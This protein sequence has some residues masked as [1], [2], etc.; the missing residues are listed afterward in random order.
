MQMFD[1]PPESSASSVRAPKRNKVQA[2][3]VP[4]SPPAVSIL[5]LMCLEASFV[6]CSCYV[7]QLQQMHATLTAPKHVPDVCP[8]CNVCASK[9]TRAIAAQVAQVDDVPLPAAPA[10]AL[11]GIWSDGKPAR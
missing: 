6:V 3:A 9:F 2:H 8:T 10:D 1:E 4:L 11:A 7:E 5:C